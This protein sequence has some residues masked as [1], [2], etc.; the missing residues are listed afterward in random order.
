MCRK[1]CISTRWMFWF[2][3]FTGQVSAARPQGSM[4]ENKQKSY[5]MGVF[6]LVH[7]STQSP[8]GWDLLVAELKARGHDC[9]CA[10][11]PTDEPEASATR[12]ARVISSTL[13]G[14][15]KATV[16]A[17]SVSGLFLPLVPDYARVGRLVYLGAVIPEPGESFLAQY[18]R[19][20]EMYRP[21]FVGKDPTK[22]AAL[23][24]HYLFHDCPAD[25]VP[26]AISTLRLMFAKQALIEQSPLKTWPSVPTS[27]ISCTEDRTLNPE[28]WEN[29]A[30]TR[31]RTEPI[32]IK[33]GHAPHISRPGELAVILD[34]LETVV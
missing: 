24:H 28:W 16:V 9:V 20:P 31:L 25:V 27:Y 18:Q 8:S 13:V 1:D 3:L 12:Y 17:H 7:G 2:R 21:D 34:S 11:L 26:W 33:A 32:Q 23:A 30:R 19:A 14:A 6:C 22:D 4:N 29:A 15:T 10:D 5:S